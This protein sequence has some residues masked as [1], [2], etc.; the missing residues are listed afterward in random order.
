MPIAR[1]RPRR[2]AASLALAACGLLA[3]CGGDDASPAA[4]AGQPARQAVPVEVAEARQD[5]L[6]VRLTSVGSLEAD[7]VVEVRPET[8]GTV[9]AIAVDE[10]D[11]VRR[12]QVLVRLDAREPAAELAAAEAAVSRLATELDNLET[13]LERNRGLF[14][15]GAIS[16]QTLDDLESGRAAAAARLREAEA[17]RDLAARRLEKSVL[18]APFAGRVGQRSVYPGDYVQEGD[19]LFAL[20]DDDPLKVEF[21]VPEQYVG[22]LE[23][24]TP[25]TVM[26]RSLPGERFEGRVVFIGPRIDPASRTA[27]LKAAVPNADGRLRPGQF[28][29]VELELERRE[30]ALVVPEAAVVPRGG[31]NF[32]FVVAPDGTAGER[33]VE[34]GQRESGRVE[35]RAGVRAGERVVVAGQQ[36]LRDGTPVELVEGGGGDEPGGEP[37]GEPG[38]AAAA[39]AEG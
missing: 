8:S 3:G 21:S 20:V 19:A 38:V 33:R 29:D 12:G 4:A 6:S 30:N 16:R 39:G 26:V 15:K 14:D 31:E 28:A 25:V 1:L 24:G 9:A 2:A 35:V 36:R 17:Q 27:S 13:R 34:L 11:A 23:P 5:P 18:T 7:N 22:R 32:V 10:G 37:G